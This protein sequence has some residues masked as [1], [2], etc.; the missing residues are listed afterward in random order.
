MKTK[1]EDA[2]DRLLARYRECL[3]AIKRRSE[4]LA[5]ELRAENRGDELQSDADDIAVIANYALTG[6]P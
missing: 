1:K 2:T 5:V 3:I 4:T 6:A